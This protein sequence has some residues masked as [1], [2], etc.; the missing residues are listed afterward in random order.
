M[1]TKKLENMSV[2]ELRARHKQVTGRSTKEGNKKKLIDAIEQHERLTRRVNDGAGAPAQHSAGQRRGRAG[3]QAITATD[4]NAAASATDGG[5][6]PATAPTG[7]KP[8]RGRW[9]AM[10]VEELRALYAEKIGRTTDSTDRAYLIWKLREAEK[11]HITIGAARRGGRK[12]SDEPML[13]VTLRLP[14]SITTQMDEVWKRL[15]LRSRIDLIERA[16]GRGFAALHESE[17]AQAFDAR[18]P[19]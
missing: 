3:R 12:L 14:V 19:N 5:Q 4:A 7:E 6:A 16:M 13:P 17:L 8:A 11:G 15:S 10:T 18:R 2:T 1:A 9:A